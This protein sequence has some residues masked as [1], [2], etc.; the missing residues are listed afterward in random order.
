MDLY[1]AGNPFPL[2]GPLVLVVSLPVAML[3]LPIA[4]AVYWLLNV[5]L[6]LA[7]AAVALRI[8][9][10]PLSPGAVAGLA[11]VLLLSRPGHAN[12]YFGQ[13]TL[14]MILVTIGSW[15][16]AGQRP[17]L[18]GLLLT[19]ALIKPTF[20]VP[21]SVLLI[22]QGKWRAA[23]TGLAITAVVSASIVALLLFRSA[24]AGGPHV[25]DLLKTNQTALEDDPNV[26]P[27]RSGSRIDLPMVVER[28]LGDRVSLV[29]RWVLP[30]LV[31]G[32]SG[33]VLRKLDSRAGGSEVGEPSALSFSLLCVT[34]AICIYHGV[35]DGLLAAVPAVAA[36][37]GV[38]REGFLRRS[39]SP[40]GIWNLPLAICLSIPAVNYFSS[41]QFWA[42]LSQVLPGP[43]DVGASPSGPLWAAACILNG[44]CLSI[45][46]CLLLVA[47]LR[48]PRQEV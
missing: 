1:P 16:F 2:Y 41:K 29:A 26:H 32:I 22:V 27:K 48:R 39:A 37:Q 8:C 24:D 11:A 20:G 33:C 13:I 30:L 17:L 42:T 36:W 15:H 44:V 14:P 10:I 5:V 18:S 6:L 35:Y 19:L 4:Q 28:A 43:S 31:L 45:V 7:F 3:P 21:L 40:V 34:I 9:S 12:L 23:F 47:I 46:W 25:F 38:L